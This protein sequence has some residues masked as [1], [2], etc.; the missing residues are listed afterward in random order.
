[1]T[2]MACH[3]F[4]KDNHPEEKQVMVG[5]C[6]FPFAMHSTSGACTEYTLL[7]SSRFCRKIFSAVERRFDS[8]PSGFGHFLRMS[9]ITRPRYVR[10]RFV[11]RFERFGWRE[12]C[13]F[14]KLTLRISVLL[15]EG[16]NFGDNV[17]PQWFSFYGEGQ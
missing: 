5:V 16:H 9:R 7:L 13:S 10:I 3:G 12:I 15:L 11:S 1:M 4:S 17:T 6:A 14:V 8:L 2:E